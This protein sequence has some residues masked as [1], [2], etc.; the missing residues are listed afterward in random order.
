MKLISVL[1]IVFILY[2]RKL[3]HAVIKSELTEREFGPR[4]LGKALFITIML[5]LFVSGL[6]HV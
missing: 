1:I 6:K 4:Q 3:R 2:M 5:K